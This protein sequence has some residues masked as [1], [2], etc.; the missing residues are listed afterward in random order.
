MEKDEP[1]DKTDYR[2]ANKENES[3]PRKEVHV[4]AQPLRPHSE[5]QEKYKT[6]HNEDQVNFHLQVALLSYEYVETS[7]T[8][9]L[10]NAYFNLLWFLS[11]LAIDITVHIFGWLN[12]LQYF[13]LHQS[14]AEL[15]RVLNFLEIIKFAD[16]LNLF[17]HGQDL[18]LI[19]KDSV[20]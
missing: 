15:H 8:N 6:T 3:V 14:K 10:L 19:G 2:C 4:H 11:L 7:S 16:L 9:S 17:T 18:V 20:M 13:Q 1:N 5:Q 12:F